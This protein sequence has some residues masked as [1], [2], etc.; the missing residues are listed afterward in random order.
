MSYHGAAMHQ[1][2]ISTPLV[3][4]RCTVTQWVEWT[5]A[6]AD[7][8]HGSVLV[9]IQPE[10]EDARRIDVAWDRVEVARALETVAGTERLRSIEV[11][12]DRGFVELRRRQRWSGRELTPT[13]RAGP[14]PML[15]ERACSIT[16][17]WAGAP[18]DAAVPSGA[19]GGRFLRLMQAA[20]ALCAVLILASLGL[21]LAGHETFAL[22]TA[23]ALLPPVAVGLWSHHR[24]L[25]A[26]VEAGEGLIVVPDR[27]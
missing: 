18:A 14:H 15:V 22:W 2:A 11:R 3:H 1:P 6:I 5:E 23:L 17:H 9:R 21:L 27:D 26:S 24:A 4:L 7:V 13:L 8:L 16:R 20:S 25:Q 19:P 10:E 12:G